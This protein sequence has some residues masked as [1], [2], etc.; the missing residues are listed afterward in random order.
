VAPG[1]FLVALELLFVQVGVGKMFAVFEFEI[2]ALAAELE[3]E[4]E[5]ALVLSLDLV[6]LFV[7]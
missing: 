5:S 3:L 1:E 6:A 2:V 4:P 7:A